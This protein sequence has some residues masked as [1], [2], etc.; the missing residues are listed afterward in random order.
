MLNVYI[1]YD[2]REHEAFEVCRHSLIRRSSEPVRVVA[3]DQRE[4]RAKDLYTRSY[5]VEANGQMVDDRDGKP[6]STEFTF[7]RFLVPE[8][9]R[10]DGVEDGALF[11]DCDFLFLD[12]VNLLFLSLMEPNY[13]VNVVKHNYLPISTIKMDGVEQ[14]RYPRKLWSSLMLFNLRH[15]ATRSLTHEVVNT[16]SGGDLHGFKWCPEEAIGELVEDWNWIPGASPTTGDEFAKP[17]GAIHYSEGGPWF[18]KYRNAPLSDLWFKERDHMI[19]ARMN[20]R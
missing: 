14:H 6:F 16:W 13:A 20:Y 4:L 12:D 2:P 3:L 9:A 1:G 19:A 15:E 10:R 11:V 5:R 18:P 7:T 17:T 8:L